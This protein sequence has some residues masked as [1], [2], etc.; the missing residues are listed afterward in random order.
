[1]RDGLAVTS[2]ARSILDSAE[3]GTAPEQIEMAIMQALSRSMVIADKLRI[4]SNERN[5]RVIRLIANA[6][7]R[8]GS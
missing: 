5:R 2:A 3:T 6:L 8:A 1:M 7:Q 4:D